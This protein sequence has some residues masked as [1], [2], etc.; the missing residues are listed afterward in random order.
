MYSGDKCPS[1]AS[2]KTLVDILFDAYVIPAIGLE[3]S[4]QAVSAPTRLAALLLSATALIGPNAVAEESMETTVVVCGGITSE[5][6][7]K[8]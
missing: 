3:L 5:Y 8:I 4:N 6:I 7:H 1:L 2:S